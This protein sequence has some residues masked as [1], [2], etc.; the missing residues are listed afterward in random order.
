MR[1][2]KM[3]RGRKRSKLLGGHNLLKL[4]L[5]DQKKISLF[6]DENLYKELRQ[7][8]KKSPK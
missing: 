7:L 4:L 6:L 3:K 5:D 2:L 1:I 8:E